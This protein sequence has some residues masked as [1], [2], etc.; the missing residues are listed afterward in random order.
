MITCSHHAM[1]VTTLIVD[2]IKREYL[3]NT[4]PKLIEKYYGTRVIPDPI[5]QVNRKKQQFYDKTISQLENELQ[6]WDKI[7]STLEQDSDMANKISTIKME[8]FQPNVDQTT[9]EMLS[10]LTKLLN[11][12]IESTVVLND[13]LN[14]FIEEILQTKRDAN[15]LQQKVFHKMK[16]QR[17]PASSD[18][19][20]AT[21]DALVSNIINKN[22]NTRTEK[23]DQANALDPKTII[24]EKDFK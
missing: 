12:C 24:G 16:E 14:M 8:S 22:K 3:T 19:K 6:F 18:S 15:N 9:S 17:K 20:T 2:E 7:A 23:K 10:T 5:N 21:N 11:G 13:H 4:L 1:I